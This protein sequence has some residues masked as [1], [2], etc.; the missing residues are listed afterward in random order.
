MTAASPQ[1]R[2][3]RREEGRGQ[4]LH[5]S[6]AA[7]TSYSLTVF[8]LINHVIQRTTTNLKDFVIPPSRKHAFFAEYLVFLPVAV[9]LV[10]ASLF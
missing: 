9:E 7:R 2:L 5:T 8:P 10:L 1:L 6:R 3:L 4:D